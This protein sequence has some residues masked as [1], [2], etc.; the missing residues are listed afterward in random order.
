[1]KRPLKFI[2]NKIKTIIGYNVL[3]T[4]L[5]VIVAL[6]LQSLFMY[7]FYD[8]ILTKHTSIVNNILLEN[9]IDKIEKDILE[10]EKISVVLNANSRVTSFYGAGSELTNDQAYQAVQ[11]VKDLKSVKDSNRLI[12]KVLITLF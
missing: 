3:K 7:S 2:F 4:Y 11:I 5:I 10:L 6:V 9:S 1:M 12:D 8:D